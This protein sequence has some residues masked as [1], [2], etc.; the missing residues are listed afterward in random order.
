[1]EDYILI[2]KFVDFVKDKLED[3]VE[4]LLNDYMTE[5]NEVYNT[6]MIINDYDLSHTFY[7]LVSEIYSIGEG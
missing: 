3:D 6:E 7:E 1:M 5:F 2:D 4:E